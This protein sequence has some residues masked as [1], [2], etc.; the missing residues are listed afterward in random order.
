[1]T[2]TEERLR[3]AF[4]GAA[5]TVQDEDLRPLTAPIPR[6][7]RA[8]WTLRAPRRHLPGRSMPR[9][10]AR[11]WMVPRW[12]VRRWAVPRPD[13]LQQV[14]QR[15]ALRQ[16]VPRWVVPV[17]AAVSVA[18]VAMGTLVLVRDVRR[19]ATGVVVAK[20]APR[21]FL[22]TEAVY[23]KKEK[24]G[25]PI[26]PGAVRVRSSET[27]AVVATVPVV[28][29]VN[30]GTDL[31]L[32]AAP[33]GRAYIVRG[34]LSYAAPSVHELYRAFLVRLGP[35]GTPST[36]VELRIAALR[37]Q[38]SAFALSPDAGRVGFV[39]GSQ[40]GVAD[41]ATGRVRT[42]P[43]RAGSGAELQW[44]DDGR[45]LLLLAAQA[46]NKIWTQTFDPDLRGGRVAGRIALPAGRSYFPEG[47]YGKEYLVSSGD[48]T[49]GAASL[50][51]VSAVTGQVTGT[52]GSW[53]APRAW[54][55][56]PKPVAQRTGWAFE[57]ATGHLLLYYDGRVT[58]RDLR[59]GQSR[60]L[61][62]VLGGDLVHI[63]W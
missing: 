31:G 12:V 34:M 47:L 4:T 22:S 46:P 19:P 49:N 42:V 20:A 41:L 37:D 27:G 57:A 15:V 9:R 35:D 30:W 11:R 55:P 28:K 24:D 17:V 36:P 60:A 50:L 16:A 6:T 13:A 32:A 39:L 58:V 7:R 14:A 18:V 43:V 54:P 3:D 25:W 40:V 44:S 63:E 59:T 29:G 62:A 21:F 56:P 51:R 52:L 10:S 5:Q 53:T 33:G 26:Q 1:M 2:G 48:E 61:P 45:R 23:G 38:V 8:L